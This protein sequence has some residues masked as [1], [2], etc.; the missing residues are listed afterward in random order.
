MKRLQHR[1]R[2]APMLVLLVDG[3]VVHRARST[4]LF[5]LFTR[6]ATKPAD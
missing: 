4:S 1:R 5:E 3:Q 2:L 6:K